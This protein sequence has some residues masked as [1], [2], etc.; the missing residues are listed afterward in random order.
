MISSLTYQKSAF[1][2]PI[3]SL[4]VTGEP[5]SPPP[6]PRPRRHPIDIASNL[7]YASGF[8]GGL[9]P[10]GLFMPPLDHIIDFDDT[11]VPSVTLKPRK[12]S[13]GRVTSVDKQQQRPLG[14]RPRRG[15]CR[16]RGHQKS[17]CDDL[18]H[19]AV[20]NDATVRDIDAVRSLDPLW[21]GQQQEKMNAC[22]SSRLFNPYSSGRR[23][24]NSSKVFPLP[25]RN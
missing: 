17:D 6:A 2:T 23:S 12:E 14:L 8:D 18:N 3:S 24:S 11:R 21:D 4:T 9:L 22:G 15:A 13:F 1:I 20:I 16:S 5:S 25:E 7:V 19:L 10:N